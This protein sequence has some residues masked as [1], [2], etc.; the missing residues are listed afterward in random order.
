MTNDKN[1]RDEKLQDNSNKTIVQGNRVAE[2]ISAL[3]SSKTDKKEY[4]PGQEILPIDQKQVIHETKL[5][6]VPLRRAFEKQVKT[7]KERGKQLIEIN[8]LDK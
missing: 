6:Y 5:T 2:K 8:M 1:L 3:L 4:L 7:I